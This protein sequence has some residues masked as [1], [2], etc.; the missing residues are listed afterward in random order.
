MTHRKSFSV[1]G[2]VRTPRSASAP[3]RPGSRV[4]GVKRRRAAR[5]RASSETFTFAPGS[6]RFPSAESVH[7]SGTETPPVSAPWTIFTS[8]RGSL[9]SGSLCP[10]SDAS[11]RVAVAVRFGRAISPSPATSKESVPE[12]S[13]ET[14]ESA[15]NAPM[16]IPSAAKRARNVFRSS[17]IEPDPATTPP[18]ISAR[19]SSSWKVPG[20]KR[21]FPVTSGTRWPQITA[22]RTVTGPPPE[23]AA[24]LPT[25]GKLPDTRPSTG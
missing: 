8:R 17:A 20:E 11:E 1:A 18:S 6:R 22:S 25:T 16:G 5:S 12:T 24:A 2:S 15:D 19:T 9:P 7:L 10:K 23:S 14:S 21:S 4:N 3:P 13:S